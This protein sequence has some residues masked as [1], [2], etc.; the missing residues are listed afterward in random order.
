MKKLNVWIKGIAPLLMHDVQGIN[1][2]DKRVKQ[3]KKITAKKPK[4]RTDEDHLQ[5]YRLEWDLG[6]YTGKDG[7]PMIPAVN[8]EACIRDTAK[9]ERKGKLVTAGI[10][11]SPDEIP[12]IY[13]GPETKDALWEEGYYDIRAAGLR[14]STVNRC[15]PRFNNW[16]LKFV[17]EYSERDFDDEKIPE[18]LSLSG[19]TGLGDYRTRYGKFSLMSVEPIK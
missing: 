15:R 11:V 13:P 3:I 2:L 14:G 18:L 16:E 1:P 9:K 10:K 7:K 5:M 6:L 12:L 8:V 4:E 19:A 17:L